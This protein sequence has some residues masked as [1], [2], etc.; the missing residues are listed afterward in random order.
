MGVRYTGKQGCYMDIKVG[1][2]RHEAV[3]SL[4]QEHHED[5]L[6]HSPP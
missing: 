2:F 1:E 3:I 4:L 5:M 6:A